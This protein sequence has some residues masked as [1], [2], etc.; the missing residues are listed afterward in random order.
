MLL[1][2]LIRNLPK[3]KKNIDIKGLEIN[4][5][6]VKKGFIFFA[7]RGQKINGEK[8]I[9]ESVKNG[10][11]V[12]ICSKNCN[13]KNKNLVVI[14]T[15][16]VR[17]L[18]SE[19]ASKFYKLKPKNL[20]A[21][22]GTNGKTSVADLY[23][24]ILNLNKIPTASIGTLG[25]KYKKKTDK[26]DLTTPDTLNLHRSLQKI[27]KNNINN[28]IIET[29]SH[30]L[31]QRRLDHL[32]FKAG[33]FTNFSQDHLDYHKTMAKYL[34]AKLHLFRN[35]IKKKQ[36]II[37]DRMI[38]EFSLLKKISKKRKLKLIDSD[39]IAEKLKK[40]AQLQ[41]FFNNMVYHL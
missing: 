40:N 12:V 1:K 29:S 33:I 28:V 26:S 5:K 36:V 17:L 37:C 19:L 13:Y 7:I 10:A 21:V 34:N 30:G 15:K 35:V 23:F 41:E 25:V 4:S 16:N 39:K 14:K 2:Q 8:Y 6:N 20:I 9:S 32:D 22:T 18:L 38:K 31:H 11:K 3:E 24:Q 27:R